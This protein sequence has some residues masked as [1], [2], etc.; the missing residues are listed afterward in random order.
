MTSTGRVIIV[1]WLGID[2]YYQS[3]PD[4]SQTW[5]VALSWLANAEILFHFAYIVKGYE[6]QRAIFHLGHY[7]FTDQLIS[8][9][10]IFKYYSTTAH[11]LCNSCCQKNLIQNLITEKKKTHQSPHFILRRRP[12]VWRVTHQ[13]FLWARTCFC[14]V[15]LMYKDTAVYLPRHTCQ[16]FIK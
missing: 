14:A 9:G 4:V 15:R 3:A 6:L 16:E 1:K 5:F 2:L 10:H 12:P 8:E 7:M 11:F 13:L